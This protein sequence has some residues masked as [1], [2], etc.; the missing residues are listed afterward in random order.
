MKSELIVLILSAIAG[1]IGTGIGGVVGAFVKDK[2]PSAVANMLA[3]AAGTMLGITA[4]EMLPEAVR[5]V[6]SFKAEFLGRVLVI[7]VTFA[8]TAVAAL[9]GFLTDKASK[10]RQIT[11]LEY[12][13]RKRI[14]DGGKALTRSEN[15]LKTAGIATFIAIA[16]HNIPEGMAI[17]A[18]GAGSL[19]AGIVVAFVIAL[20]NVPE[21]MAVSAPLVGGGIKPP[22][23]VALSLA[24]GSTTLAGAVI[25]ML[26]GGINELACGLSVSLA[27][28]VMIF[29]ACFDLLPLAARMRDS[30]P[31]F[32]FFMGIAVALVFSLLF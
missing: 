22:K 14:A 8:G 1:I 23:A 31:S 9:L 11:A 19:M 6:N 4:F 25:G 13:K 26:V 3:F 17:G 29:V 18:S 15:G 2:S 12:P 27:S 7:C 21:G 32:S 28:G 16:L 20:H 10:K 24:A 5:N 30:F